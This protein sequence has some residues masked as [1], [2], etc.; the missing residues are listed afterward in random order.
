MK[1]LQPIIKQLQ[2]RGVSYRP[3]V[4][5]APYTTFHIGGEAALLIEPVSQ[6]QLLYAVQAVRAH[7]DQVVLLGRASNVLLPDEPMDAAVIRTA[8]IRDTSLEGE[9]ISAACGTSLNELARCA[10]RAGLRGLEFAYGIPGTLG[11]ALCMNAGAYGFDMASV[12]SW[13][14][15]YDAEQDRIVFLNREQMKFSYRHS[16]LLSAP[17]LTALCAGFSLQ[18][19]DP[20]QIEQRMQ[21]YMQE[22]K[23][24]QP[25]EYPSAGSVFKRP[26]GAFAGQLIEQSGL[27]GYR[28]GGAMVSPKHA[29][30]IINVGGATAKDVLELIEHIRRTVLHDHG[31]LLET[32]VQ[33]LTSLHAR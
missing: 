2:E 30:F 20:G 19:D 15:L 31:I 12:V 6:E 17:H 27:K 14:R 5:M 21:R 23:S 25:L 11:G 9:M 26:K 7:D 32:E 16:V 22:R 1:A 4:V 10:Q 28:I 13:V 3:N 29:G 18:R 8:L 24:K 33:I